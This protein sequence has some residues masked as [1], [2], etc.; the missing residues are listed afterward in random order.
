M[1]DGVYTI[2]VTGEQ[3]EAISELF[4]TKRWKLNVDENGRPF[5]F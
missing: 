3:L 5:R 1:A 2:E 4:H